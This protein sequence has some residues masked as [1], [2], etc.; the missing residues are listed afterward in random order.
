MSPYNDKAH[1]LVWDTEAQMP[2]VQLM[3]TLTLRIK[4]C[5]IIYARVALTSQ[6]WMKIGPEEASDE[7]GLSRSHCGCREL[8]H[9]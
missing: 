4:Q 2:K 9:T 7:T 6:T 3:R 8:G 1:K 5:D